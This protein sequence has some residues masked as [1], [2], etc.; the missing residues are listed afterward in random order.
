ML[1]LKIVRAQSR[2]DFEPAIAGSGRIGSIAGQRI[3]K[4]A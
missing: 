1:I 3:S 4:V 2:S